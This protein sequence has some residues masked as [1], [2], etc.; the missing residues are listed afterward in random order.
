MCFFQLT[1]YPGKTVSV[2]TEQVLET[3]S[4]RG[5]SF[6]L[7]LIP[8][9]QV[10]MLLVFFLY[11]IL[12]IQL[13]LSIVPVFLYYISFFTM[14]IC[15]MQMFYA[16]RKLRDIQVMTQILGRF[17]KSVDSD[18]A[19]STFC[20]NSLT[21]YWMFFGG[22][23]VCVMNFAI[24]KKEWIP[25]SECV[26]ISVLFFV[27]CFFGL[28]DRYDYLVILSVGFDLLSSLPEVFRA[29]PRI[30]VV[31]HLLNLGVGNVFSLEIV[32]GL[33][34][35]LGFPSLSYVIIPLL[36]LRMAMRKS[37]QGTYRVLIP[38]LVCFFWWKLAVMFFTHSSW[39]GLIRGS[40]GWVLIVLLPLF[41]VGMIITTIVYCVKIFSVSNLL[42]VL[43]TVAL[44]TI[45]AVLGLW[46]Q[47]GF[48]A[49]SFSFK[50]HTA[51]TKLILA[52][53]S[54]F[55]IIPL[56]YVLSPPERDVHGDFLTW[57]QYRHSCSQPAWERTNMADAQVKCSHLKHTMVN[58]SG[59]V[60]KV[61]IAKTENQAESF[62]DILPVGISDYLKCVYG[63]KY[64]ECE[65]GNFTNEEERD[66]CRI[67]TMQ[68]R[69]CHIKR[70]D[71]YTFNIWVKME[72]DDETQQD[73]ILVT[74]NQFRNIA[75]LLRKDDI[76]TFRASIKNA[77]GGLRP[78]LYVFHLECTSCLNTESQKLE[79]ESSVISG[80]QKSVFSIFNFVMSPLLEFEMNEQ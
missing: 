41:G 33:N 7:S 63:D 61:V 20:W 40:F 65:S 44:I 80:V 59:P 30:P 17:S 16:K 6:L 32:P 73:V 52:M 26:F 56:V 4:K 35:N 70:M 19:E 12:S 49:R 27:S 10:H 76:V 13:V 79:T 48:R 24:A 46:A 50:N 3:A 36:F 47:T 53:L 23:A 67:H 5:M 64:P 71:H 34:L 43:T 21:P 14:I 15:T 69:T 58:W 60:S 42:K 72:I 51:K 22:L 75:M 54:V 77:M 39:M 74:R 45:P 8:T 62:L 66:L 68:G 38:H 25:C 55:S 1:K 78:E 31:Y 11:S 18:T 9:H 29:F 37:W 57:D 28:N 2:L